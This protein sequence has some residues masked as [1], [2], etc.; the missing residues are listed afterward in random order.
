MRE[1]ISQLVSAFPGVSLA[2]GRISP[3]MTAPALLSS[4]PVPMRFGMTLSARKGLL[5]NA[6][7][8]TADQSPLFAPMMQG[9]R[10]LIP[11]NDFYEWDSAKRPH[12]FHPPPGQL[13]Y[14]AGLYMRAKPL[15]CYVI[16][17]READEAVSPIHHRMPLLMSSAEYCEAWL[18]SPALALELLRIEPDLS[19]EV[20]S[21]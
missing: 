7:S 10:C 17:T 6:R 20:R 12:T 9:A 14:M 19:L 18:R 15:P 16:L 21:A 8:E 2:Q 13:L 4:G 5:L 1:I 3:S 11:A